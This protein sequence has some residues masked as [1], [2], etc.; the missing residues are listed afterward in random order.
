[1]LTTLMLFCLQFSKNQN[2]AKD[3]LVLFKLW[4]PQLGGVGVRAIKKRTQGNTD[5]NS[6]EPQELSMFSNKV[7]SFRSISISSS[8]LPLCISLTSHYFIPTYLI[9]YSTNVFINLSYSVYLSFTHT[10]TMKSTQSI[11]HLLNLSLNHSIYHS[12]TQSI[13]HLLNLSL[14]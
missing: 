14:T 12:L 13:T 3:I 11:T 6:T 9:G 10:V 2:L 5:I 1:M 7:L 4:E 8:V